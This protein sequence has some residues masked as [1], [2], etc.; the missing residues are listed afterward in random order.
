MCGV[1]L[2]LLNL[3]QKSVYVQSN[4]YLVNRLSNGAIQ[5]TLRP[6]KRQIRSGVELAT[7]WIR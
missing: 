3:P 2:L 5:M 1:R 4:S 6:L 7:L